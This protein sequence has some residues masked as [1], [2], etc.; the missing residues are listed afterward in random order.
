MGTSLTAERSS[1]R[2]GRT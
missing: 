1:G 2:S